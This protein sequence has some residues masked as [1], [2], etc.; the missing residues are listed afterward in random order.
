MFKVLTLTFAPE[1]G[2]DSPA[3]RLPGA[4][5]DGK[6]PVAISA[7]LHDTNTAQAKKGLPPKQKKELRFLVI[8]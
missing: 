3:L 6:T 5:T 7:L 2:R 4:G 1:V 8:P